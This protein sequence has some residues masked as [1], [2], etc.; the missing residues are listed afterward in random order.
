MLGKAMC[1]LVHERKA[2][3]QRISFCV[4]EIK[5]K[6]EGRGTGFRVGVA[7]IPK[8]GRIE[9]STQI[10]GNSMGR[11]TLTWREGEREK[12]RDTDRVKSFDREGDS[13][14]YRMRSD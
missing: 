13:M 7:C 8:A 4:R 5:D 1:L 6:R 2:S 11:L 12:E 14:L 9:K 10:E 3:A